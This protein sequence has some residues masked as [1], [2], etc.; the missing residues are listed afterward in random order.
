MRILRKPK[1]RVLRRKLPRKF[2]AREKVGGR[3][4]RAGESP[5]GADVIA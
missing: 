1:R 5:N 4:A 3:C 2:K